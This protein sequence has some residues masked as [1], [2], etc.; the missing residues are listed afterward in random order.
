MAGLDFNK[1]LQMMG[2]G[3][4]LNLVRAQIINAT[5]VDQDLIDTAN[6]N[7]TAIKDEISKINSALSSGDLPDPVKDPVAYGKYA[8]TSLGDGVTV[9]WD[10]KNFAL[11]P[12]SRK[13][14]TQL[15]Q[16]KLKEYGTQI[17]TLEGAIRS[18]KSAPAAN[19]QATITQ[20][21]GILLATGLKDEERA[22]ALDDAKIARDERMQDA[23]AAAAAAGLIAD[24]N[25]IATM[26]VQLDDGTWKFRQILKDGTAKDTDYNPTPAERIKALYNA[27]DGSI[28]SIGK[29]GTTIQWTYKPPRLSKEGDYTYSIEFDP[30]KQDYVGKKT[31]ISSPG[32]KLE[33]YNGRLYITEI[34]DGKVTVTKVEDMPDM[35]EADR[36]RLENESRNTATA[37][38]NQLLAAAE[39]G[40]KVETAKFA[41][42]QAKEGKQTAID[43]LNNKMTVIQ[44]LI[45]S[46]TAAD[47][48]KAQELY[49][50]AR[51]DWEVEKKNATERRDKAQDKGLRRSGMMFLRGATAVQGGKTGADAQKMWNEEYNRTPGK[52]GETYTERMARSLGL[53]ADLD[54]NL[55]TTF[56]TLPEFANGGNWSV[57]PAS[58][59]AVPAAVA[60][61]TSASRADGKV[62]PA[63][64]PNIATTTAIATRPSGSITGNTNAAGYQTD[65]FPTVPYTGT[66]P[67]KATGQQLN[68]G[69]VAVA[70]SSMP[71][72]NYHTGLNAAGQY[73]P[74]QAN[75]PDVVAPLPDSWK[76][77]TPENYQNI[78]GS[79]QR[80]DVNVND[81][82]PMTKLTKLHARLNGFYAE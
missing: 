64:N 75:V 36:I 38:K 63:S 78:Q 65:T 54:Q 60:P 27:A 5:P 72:Q 12:T 61:V 47:L 2:T 11:D 32:Q 9:Y 19:A 74:M 66:G 53:G 43:I 28:G 23:K 25:T 34:K 6:K 18:A 37:E 79:T 46:G 69:Q 1:L 57:V 77:Y 45:K 21:Q 35:S 40:I 30:D 68:Q 13:E 39:S 76:Q 22:R 14:V 15:L 42:D 3:T 7:I 62:P 73:Q 81:E 82:D 80:G 55:D 58:K 71:P 26:V 4:D 51:K 41:L 10:G 31:V 24:K 17:G 33:M 29:D 8:Q 50:S 49:Q 48:A 59:P 56:P 44:G 70:P 52:E 16:G 67:G 20:L